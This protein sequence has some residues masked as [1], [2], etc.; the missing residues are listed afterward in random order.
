M[1]ANWEKNWSFP[2][3]VTRLAINPAL[4]AGVENAE[5]CLPG[6][7]DDAFAGRFG[8]LREREDMKPLAA[9]LPTM[10]ESLRRE[11]N[12]VG[13]DRKAKL[14]PVVWLR[15]IQEAGVT[16]V[17][18]MVREFERWQEQMRANSS[19]ILYRRFDEVKNQYVGPVRYRED[20]GKVRGF[21]VEEM[22]SE[23]PKQPNWPYCYEWKCVPQKPS[24]A[25]AQQNPEA[26]VV[27]VPKLATTVSEKTQTAKAG[28][29]NPRRRRKRSRQELEQAC[30][31]RVMTALDECMA[32]EFF[33]KR[34]SVLEAGRK[35]DRRTYKCQLSLDELVSLLKQRYGE[36]LIYADSTLKSAL[37][38]FVSCPRGRPG[39]RC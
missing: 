18:A 22:L 31:L 1:I 15:L 30:G 26:E 8:R 39:G 33:R 6:V 32:A 4:Y 36:Q 11:M 17:D 24:G 19:I 3:A 10:L 14:P 27:A 23:Q 7:F 20:C 29:A 12:V 28:S 2:T 35:K 9:V 13:L 37:P 34:N 16:P 38:Y 5:S 25:A 21:T